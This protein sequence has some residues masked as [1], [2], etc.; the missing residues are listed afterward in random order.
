LKRSL[1]RFFRWK[2]RDDEQLIYKFKRHHTSLN[3]EE[4]IS[5]DSDVIVLCKKIV[6]DCFSPLVPMMGRHHGLG[7]T[8]KHGKEERVRRTT[9]TCYLVCGS[10]FHGVSSQQTEPSPSGYWLG[11][12]LIN[13]VRKDTAVK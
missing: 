5:D 10:A 4:R 12:Q 11:C 6:S 2:K 9:V 8:A 1:S 3:L 7:K 13:G